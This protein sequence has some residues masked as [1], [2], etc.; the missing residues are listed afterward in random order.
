ME[1]ICQCLEVEYLMMSKAPKH[2]DIT[3][4]KR[5]FSISFCNRI[6]FSS[7]EKNVRNKELFS[8]NKMHFVELV[9]Q[10]KM[11]LEHW[12]LTPAAVPFLPSPS[13]LQTLNKI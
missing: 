8:S 6:S 4:E 1:D 5:S 3:L 11:G 10:F 12:F 7:Q 2:L 13:L 9:A